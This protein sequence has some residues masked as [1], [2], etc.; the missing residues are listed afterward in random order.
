[1]HT[2]AFFAEQSGVAQPYGTQSEKLTPD[3]R[4]LVF[5][6]LKIA[7]AEAQAS[8]D[9]AITTPRKKRTATHHSLRATS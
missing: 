3:E 5:E 8:A 1:M 6:D 2:V 9:T 4:Q 7:V